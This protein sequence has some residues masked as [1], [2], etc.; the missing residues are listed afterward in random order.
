MP[1]IDLA[2]SAVGFYNGEW[3]LGAGANKV[4]AVASADDDTSYIT[5]ATVGHRQ[6]YVYDDLPSTAAV[7]QAARIKGRA[8]IPGAASGSIVGI[9]STVGGGTVTESALVGL[10]NAYGDFVTG[11][12]SNPNGGGWTVADINANSHAGIKLNALAGGSCR[13]T[14]LL[15]QV[16]YFPVPGGWTS[17]VAALG[18]LSLLGSGLALSDMPK[19]AREIALRSRGDI[20][21]QAHEYA[22]LHRELREGR[23]ARHFLLGSV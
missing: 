23:H 7:V 18:I 15:A 1:T 5:S 16:D 9:Y 13:D 6:T 19:L 22:E 3:T 12:I 4:A 10:V 2:M 11:D 14:Y 20:H 8:A 21:V 17:L